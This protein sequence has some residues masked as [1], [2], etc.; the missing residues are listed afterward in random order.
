M[1][2]S[3]SVSLLAGLLAVIFV[4]CEKKTENFEKVSEG[5]LQQV[6]DRVYP[7][8]GNELSNP[9]L[10]KRKLPRAILTKGFVDRNIKVKVIDTVCEEYLSQTRKLDIPGLET[11]KYLTKIENNEFRVSTDNEG[12]KNGFV[13]LANGPTGWWAH[14]NYSPYTESEYPEV[15]FVQSQ[16]GNGLYGFHMYFNKPL[17]MF[18]FEIAPNTPGPDHVVNVSY[19]EGDYYRSQELFSIKQTVSTPSGARLIAAKSEQYDIWMVTVSMNYPPSA[20]AGFAITNIR[21]ALAD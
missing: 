1:K 16:A 10:P 19:Q 15:L 17:R 21:Y 6:T 9:I 2:V 4:S 8:D 5:K 7:L 11:G 13:K 18:G 3:K 20:T 14:W 12:F